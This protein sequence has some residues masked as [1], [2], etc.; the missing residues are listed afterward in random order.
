MFSLHSFHFIIL[1][2][3]L[4]SKVGHDVMPLELLDLYID[5]YI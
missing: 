4:V 1:H 5:L 2:A 3:I